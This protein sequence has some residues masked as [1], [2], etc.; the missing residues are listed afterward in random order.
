MD[1]A[2][3]IGS[4][5][6]AEAF[7]REWFGP[8]PTVSAHTSGSTGTPK[9]IELLKADMR[10]SAEGTC[11]RFGI[12]AE[13]VLGLP[14]SAGYI[15]GKMMIVRALASGAKLW[16]EAPSS[17][18]F[19]AAP[20]DVV[21]DLV[22]V[23]PAQTDGLLRLGS[24][25]VRRALIGGAP[26]TSADERRV[27]ESGIEAYATYGMTETCSNVALRRFGSET[28]EAND[29]F[30]FAVD[31]RGCL[32]VK[33]P[34]MSF[35]SL[36][37]NDLVELR[38]ER[39]FMWLGRADNIINSGGVK[40]SPEE[41]ERIIGDLMPEGRYYIT[42]RPSQRWGSEVVAVVE[43]GLRPSERERAM[44][45]A[46]L[47]AAARPK[48]WIEVDSLPRTANGKLRRVPATDL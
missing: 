32:V 38:G 16:V 25:R 37:T 4:T 27:I 34:V 5:P 18:P 45:D 3:L 9:H 30:S 47:P 10:L 15:A 29:G 28:Y 39:E 17:E 40:V 23:V 46:L 41:V 19:A 1:N 7:L 43:R 35:G 24:G 21:F 42:W 36:T 6:E 31:G 22:S 26:V 2:R 8:A 11:R 33:S 14:L 20:A 44:I 48:A 12:G 13:S